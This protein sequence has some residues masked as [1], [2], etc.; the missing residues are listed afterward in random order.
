M[1]YKGKIIPRLMRRGIQSVLKGNGMTGGIIEIDLHGFRY[2]KPW[3]AWK[4]K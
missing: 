4:K 2:K 3:P 1:L